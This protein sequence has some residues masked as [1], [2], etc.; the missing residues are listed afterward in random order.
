VFDGI[1]PQAQIV[2]A[3]VAVEGHLWCLTGA[4]GQQDPSH[5]VRLSHSH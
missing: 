2:L 4:F 3:Q 5:G 1:R